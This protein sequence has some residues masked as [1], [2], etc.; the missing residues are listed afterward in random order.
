MEGGV[1][2]T[3]TCL[4]CSLRAAADM[5]IVE[6]ETAH[7]TSAYAFTSQ[8][9]LRPQHSLRQCRLWRQCSSFSAWGA[10]WAEPL[11]VHCS[12]AVEQHVSGEPFFERAETRCGQAD[13][14][15][16]GAARAGAWLA[17]THPCSC[18][19]AALGPAPVKRLCR[20]LSQFCVAH[21]PLVCGFVAVVG[22][23]AH[24]AVVPCSATPGGRKHKRTAPACA[25]RLASYPAESGRVAARLQP[26]PA[27]DDVL[28]VGPRCDPRC[29][30]SAKAV[31]Q[32]FLC[33]AAQGWCPDCRTC[34]LRCR[35][36]LICAQHLPYEYSAFALL[37]A[38]RTSTA[39]PRSGPTLSRLQLPP[40]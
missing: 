15:N 3:A 20:M 1:P 27:I 4:A 21:E 14:G 36:T 38:T 34:M 8:C 16:V 31:A 10:C 26:S 35:D 23:R 30:P 12:T 11:H 6:V 24:T 7:N 33:L 9:G 17:R 19:A 39:A 18:S 29:M 13:A 28:V 25:R 32:A 22:L 5:N 37:N 40:W 2:T